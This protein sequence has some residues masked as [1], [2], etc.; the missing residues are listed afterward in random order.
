MLAKRKDY[1]VT[2]EGVPPEFATR[3]I[4]ATCPSA[5]KKRYMEVVEYCRPRPRWVDIRCRRR[6][7]DD[8]VD[9]QH[10]LDAW[11]PSAHAW[12]I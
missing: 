4:T 11:E 7:R 2:A 10:H 1:Y 8:V 3:I 5:A 12:I 6:R 9:P